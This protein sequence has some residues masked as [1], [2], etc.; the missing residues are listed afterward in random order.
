M[1]NIFRVTR[2]SVLLDDSLSGPKHVETLI[3]LL[4]VYMQLVGKKYI[5]NSGTETCKTLSS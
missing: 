3:E 1:K 2:I 5:I 4:M